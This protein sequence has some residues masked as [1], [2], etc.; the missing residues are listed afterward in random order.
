MMFTC[1]GTP[2]Y[3][4]PEVLKGEV[5]PTPS[6]TPSA[7]PTTA[8][9]GHNGGHRVHLHFTLHL[10]G[11]NSPRKHVSQASC[12]GVERARIGCTTSLFEPVRVSA[13]RGTASSATFGRSA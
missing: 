4:A 2:E 13:A 5:W 3:V 6:A 11:G 1:C 12:R 7:P 8:P 10:R 9:N